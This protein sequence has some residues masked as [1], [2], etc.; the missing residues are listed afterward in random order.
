MAKEK[1]KFGEW[2]KKAATKVPALMG[3]AIKV[4]TGNIGGAIEEV[5]GILG[6][7]KSPEAVALSEEFK[8]YQIDFQREMFEL[9]VADRDSARKMYISDALVQKIFSIIFLIAYIGLS[10]FLVNVLMG[11]TEIPQLAETMITM[12]WTGT[13]TKLG[14]IIDFFFGGSTDKKE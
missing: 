1:G 11:G 13:S 12:I 3:V 8:K 7:D 6:K 14:T 2:L 9:E 5:V 10:V 4:G